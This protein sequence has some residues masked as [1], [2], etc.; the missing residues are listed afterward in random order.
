VPF[1]DAQEPALGARPSLTIVAPPAPTERLT[2]NEMTLDDLDDMAELL[3]NREVM[4]FYERA[5]TREEARGW[6]EWNL[7]LYSEFG[8][9]LWLLRLRATGVFVGDCGLTPQTVDGRTYVEVGYHV[10]AS[11]QG[12]GLATEAA[13]ACRSHA[14]EA[15]GLDYLI[16]IIDPMNG[17]SQRVAA[18]SG[19]AP[20]WQTTTG[21]GRPCVIYSADLR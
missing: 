7:R 16:A 9:G 14:A 1:S 13:E 10:A 19:L 20:A 21:K 8:H 6:I 4:R 11:L 5:L 15:L 18:R 3:G 17:P 2:F 12:R